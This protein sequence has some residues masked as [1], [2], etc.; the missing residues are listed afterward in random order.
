LTI[1]LHAESVGEHAEARRP[2]SL[3]ERHPHLAAFRGATSGAATDSENPPKRGWPEQSP[4]D[5]ITSVSPIRMQACMILSS[6]PGATLS[7]AP[8]PGS[9]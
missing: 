2:E 5:T 3:A 4:S 9:P 6:E 8:D 1:H 7:A